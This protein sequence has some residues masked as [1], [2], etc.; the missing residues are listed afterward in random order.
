MDAALPGAREANLGRVLQLLHLEGPHSRAS[1]TE[2]TGLNRSTIASLIGELAER[3]LAEES[4]PEP[5]KRV[6]RPSP[7]AS[8]D[9]RVVAIAANTEVDAVTL[10]AVRLDQS[11]ALRERIAIAG[12]LG[13]EAT[14]ELIGERV[15]EWASDELA[16]HRIVGIGVAVPGLV[17]AA[18]GL[19]RQAPHLDWRDAPIRDLVAERT[20]LAVTVDNDASLGALA[21]HL[22]GAARGVDDVVYLDSAS[23][24]GG[25]LIVHG[26]PVTGAAGYAGEFGQNRPGIA[27]P[28]DQRVPGGVLE[29]EVNRDRVLAMMA[30]PGADEPTLAA[31]LSASTDPA[32]AAELARQSRILATALSNAV[33][34]LNPSVVVL[35]GFLATLAAASGD[36]LA[37]VRAQCMSANG[38]ELEIRQASLGVDR[39]LVGAAEI[40][41]RDLLHHPLHASAA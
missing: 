34:V 4:A 3:G 22:Y 14:A 16:G 20:G 11:V 24:I 31:A 17:R 36:L 1:L 9:P 5:T 26:M 21:E 19:V 18:D 38:E 28:A 7:M 33:N 6:G 32:V 29:D 27:D 35:G 40:A 2:R 8:V 37:L 25:G 12:P 15:R 13:P 41:F 39:L 23:G 10:G 30:M